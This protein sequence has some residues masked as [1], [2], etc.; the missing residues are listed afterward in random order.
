MSSYMASDGKLKY[1]YSAADRRE[2]LW[3]I[4][5]ALRESSDLSLDPRHEADLQRL[6]R[7]LQDWLRHGGH[8]EALDQAGWRSHNTSSPI[9]DTDEDYGVLFEDTPTD[10]ETVARLPSSF[11]HR[12]SSRSRQL[13]NHSRS[14][15]MT[16]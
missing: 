15:R 10:Q 7:F 4:E 2:G 3:R 14:L 1:V 6:R 13:T 9:S 5:D 12:V 16:Q 11:R 8:F